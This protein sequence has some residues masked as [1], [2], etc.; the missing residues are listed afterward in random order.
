MPSSKGALGG[1]LGMGVLGGR[2]GFVRQREVGEQCSAKDGI[3][4]ELA[5]KS[6]FSSHAH[7]V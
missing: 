6:S 7:R 2:V 5:W 3:V 4:L 1:N